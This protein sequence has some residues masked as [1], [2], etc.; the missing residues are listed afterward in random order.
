MMVVCHTSIQDLCY[1]PWSCQ[2]RDN[3][4]GNCRQTECRGGMGSLREALRPL[5]V[6]GC[7]PH[8]RTSLALGARGHHRPLTRW[9][10]QTPNPLAIT[11]PSPIGHHRPLTHWPPQT[12]CISWREKHC[13]ECKGSREWLY[14][15]LCGVALA[16]CLRHCVAPLLRAPVRGLGAHLRWSHSA[17][18]G[19]CRG[20][21]EVIH[22]VVFSVM[23]MIWAVQ[24]LCS[25]ARLCDRS[26]L[27]SYQWTGLCRLKD[28]SQNPPSVQNSVS[29]SLVYALEG[30]YLARL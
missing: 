22:G 14:L 2:S 18:E 5:K 15:S 28:G 25:G 27:R 4:R 21:R 30:L 3:M 6:K 19:C 10:S 13:P 26:A 23:G 11:D 9:P 1:L 20:G 16:L 7:P 29:G 17:F 12:H 8:T 24:Y